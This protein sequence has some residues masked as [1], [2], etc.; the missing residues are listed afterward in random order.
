MDHIKNTILLV[1]EH[2][3]VRR[4]AYISNKTMFILDTKRN[5][6]SQAMDLG[7]NDSTVTIGVSN[8]EYDEIQTEIFLGFKHK[9][10][11]IN[12]IGGIKNGNINI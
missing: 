5:A 8:E 7:A 12:Q 6:L 4:S 11:D 1:W 2:G 3:R 9:R 10:K